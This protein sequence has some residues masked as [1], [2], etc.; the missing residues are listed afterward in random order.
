MKLSYL[1]TTYLVT[2]D[3][4]NVGF[5]SHLPDKSI[6]HITWEDALGLEHYFEAYDQ[7]VIP[8]PAVP[9]LFIAVDTDGETQSFLA[10]QPVHIP[11]PG[12]L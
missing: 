1:V 8:D 12:E 3:G 10:Y 4:T 2:A 7:D 11:N 9:G 6:V 5:Y